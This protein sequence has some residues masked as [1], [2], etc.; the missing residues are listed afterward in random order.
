M[1]ILHLILDDF[2][3]QWILI[4]KILLVHFTSETSCG[5]IPD[6]VSPS[7]N[8]K[9]TFQIICKECMVPLRPLSLHHCHCAK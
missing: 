1:D 4:S 6:L 9:I 7:Y 3:Y 5:S 2:G 8:I